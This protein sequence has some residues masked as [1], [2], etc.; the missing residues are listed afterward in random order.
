ME[1]TYCCSARNLT[2]LSSLLSHFQFA[3]MFSVV[4]IPLLSIPCQ[5]LM[6]LVVNV[7]CQGFQAGASQLHFDRVPLVRQ[8]WRVVFV[9]TLSICNCLLLCF[10]FCSSPISP[11]PRVY[12]DCVVSSPYLP[13]WLD[14]GGKS[15]GKER[16]LWGIGHKNGSELH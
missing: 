10:S 6:I 1:P 9:V 13:L 14:S 7:L 5:F 8:R 15:G 16:E 11:V 3:I 2:L 12:Q 4:L